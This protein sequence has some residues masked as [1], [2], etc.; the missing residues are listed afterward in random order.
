MAA[1]PQ[2]VPQVRPLICPNC[3]GT[4]NLR[5]YAQT[6][7][8]VCE[9]CQTILD[10]TTPSLRVIQRFQEKQRIQP[11]IPLGSRGKLGGVLYEVIG[12]QQRALEAD[13]ETYYWS[14]YLLLNPFQGYRYL[15]EYDGHWNSGR[16]LRLLPQPLSGGKKVQ[17]GPDTFKLFQTAVAQTTYVLGEFPWQVRVGES[18]KVEDFIWVP[19]MLSAETSSGEVVWS[20]A[21]YVLGT[22]VWRAFSLP[23]SPPAAKGIYPNQP[24]PY[25]GK[26]ASAWKTLLWLLLLWFITVI[27]VMAMMPN[28]LVFEHEYS[29][30]GANKAEASFVTPIFELPGRPSNVEVTINTNLDNDWASFNFAL[31]NDDT[32]TAYDFHKEISYYHGRDSDGSYSEGSHAERI[33]LPSMPPGKY[34][35]R[36]E[37]DMDDALVPAHSMVYRLG[38]KRG[39]PDAFWFII[40][41]LLLFIPPLWISWRSYS[42]EQAR[43]QESSGETSSSSSTGGEDD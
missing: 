30:S 14:E 41:F 34:Y 25:T 12:F 28:K 23:E 13:G 11:L 32:G 21:E 7:N 31:I 15:T 20:L 43:W 17:L 6:V 26:V 18:V 38:V 19:R 36:V 40:A 1:P 24:S 27:V 29:F 22:E 10:A 35:L 2:V 5:G 33:T 4:V 16:T 8:A 9:H 39:A 3:G 37:P 42:F